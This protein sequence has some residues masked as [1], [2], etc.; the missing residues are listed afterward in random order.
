MDTWIMTLNLTRNNNTDFLEDIIA[1][2]IGEEV[3]L[4]PTDNAQNI[5]KIDNGDFVYLRYGGSG[6]QSSNNLIRGLYAILEKTK[7]DTTTNKTTFIIHA[8]YGVKAYAVNNDAYYSTL[9]PH[10]LIDYADRDALHD[11]LISTGKN[12]IS[13]KADQHFVDT[14]IA[15]TKKLKL[16][17]INRFL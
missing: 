15:V 16:D 7:F 3:E 14:F 11:K 2:G 1:K 8:C 10:D 9:L 6:N 13:R 12:S 4:L 17:I 5:D